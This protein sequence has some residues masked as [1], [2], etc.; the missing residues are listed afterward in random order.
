MAEAS[1]LN[2][3]F[4]PCD[5]RG[6]SDCTLPIDSYGGV[7][8]WLGLAMYM[9]KALRTL[10]EDYFLPC[11]HVLEEFFDL[12]ADTASSVLLVPGASAGLLLVNLAATLLVT[13]ELGLGAVIGSLIFQLL[14]VTGMTGVLSSRDDAEVKIWRYPLLRD[15]FFYVIA[16]V[17]LIVFLSDQKVEW[18]E[19][20]VMVLTYGL[21]C[22]FMRFNKRIA[23]SVVLSMGLVSAD[24]VAQVK[25]KKNEDPSPVSPSGDEVHGA[26][27]ADMLAEEDRPNSA[28]ADVLR[29]PGLGDLDLPPAPTDP[30]E[31]AP[32][33]I[34]FPNDDFNLTGTSSRERRKEQR[35]HAVALLQTHDP[36]AL[37]WVAFMPLPELATLQ[38]FGIC[39]GLIVCLAYLLVDAAT[40]ASIIL[41]IAPL[42]LGLLFVAPGMSS[43]AVINAIDDVKDGEADVAL[44]N[45]LGSSL[46]DMLVGLGLP[47]FLHGWVGDVEFK[48]SIQP[49]VMGNLVMLPII[50]LGFLL[51]LVAQRWSVKWQTS[52]A[53]LGCYGIWF[54]GNFVAM[55]VGD[56]L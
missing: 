25:K 19:A 24:E 35:K 2:T 13:S 9:C 26:R 21:Y 46:F 39:F 56:G 30:D 15:T 22:V 41:N 28:P 32:S 7:L 8:L 50:I 1:L 38:V 51:M 49:L 3:F 12:S 42:L 11:L 47:W 4:G 29:S 40:R 43:L 55:C 17:E 10:A 23:A 18:F 45:I 54:I 48:N 52:Y 6:F 37:C 20:M 27:A 34:G 16:W 31:M 33:V 36:L 14:V 53:L 44:A 5:C